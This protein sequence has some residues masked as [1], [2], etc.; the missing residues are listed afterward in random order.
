MRFEIICLIHTI[1]KEAFAS[2]FKIDH[3]WV[4]NPDMSKLSMKA[5]VNLP[6]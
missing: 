4:Y 1:K 2:P 3:L 5:V 6:D